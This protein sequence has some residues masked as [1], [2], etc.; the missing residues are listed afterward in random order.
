LREK[1]IEDEVDE[2]MHRKNLKVEV[3]KNGKWTEVA[4]DEVK[5]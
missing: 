5:R 3:R 2:M 1:S 4:F